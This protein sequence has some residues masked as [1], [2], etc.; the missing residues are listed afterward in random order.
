MISKHLPLR[1]ASW[2]DSFLPQ[3]AVLTNSVIGAMLCFAIE[4]S[5][6]AMLYYYRFMGTKAGCHFVLQRRI[7]PMLS[8]VMKMSRNTSETEKY[9]RSLPGR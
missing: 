4:W 7:C 3:R 8:I 6:Y 1:L 9:L 5:L 2:V